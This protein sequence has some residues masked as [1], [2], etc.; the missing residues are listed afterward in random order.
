MVWR[1]AQWY[2]LILTSGGTKWKR[3]ISHRYPQLISHVFSICTP[4]TPPH[5]EYISTEQLAQG[6]LPQLAYQIHLASGEVEKSVNSE[7]LIRQF[8]KGLYGGKGPNG[9]SAFDPTRGVLT[10]HLPII[11][12]SR[13][14]NGKVSLQILWHLE[15]AARECGNL[16]DYADA[17]VPDKAYIGF[18]C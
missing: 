2:G 7:Q 5:Q 15:N 8:L 17:A 18:I 10:E 11:G 14:L 3:L 1:A 16:L 12:E 6:D 13:L 9:E 4:Y